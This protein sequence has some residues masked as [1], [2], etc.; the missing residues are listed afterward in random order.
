MNARADTEKLRD[1]A[2]AE[3]TTKHAEALRAKLATGDATALHDMA[4]AVGERLSQPGIC[5]LIVGT[6]VK[7]GQFK[8][9]TLFSAVVD[10]C[11][12]ADA[13]REAIKEVERMEAAAK[14]D[15]DNCQ[16]TMRQE[17]HTHRRAA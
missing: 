15:P 14:A 10:E 13:E 3:L 1:A 17:R 4:N 5:E 2:I 6:A 8:A 7:C 11:V 12:Q 16:M 9:G